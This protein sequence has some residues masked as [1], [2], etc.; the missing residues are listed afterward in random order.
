MFKRILFGIIIAILS[1][2][3][4]SIIAMNQHKEP[5]KPRVASEAEIRKYFR[6]IMPS[7]EQVKNSILGKQG[8]GQL[9]KNKGWKFDVDL[10]W[11]LSDSIRTAGWRTEPQPT[12]FY[13]YEKDGARKC[14]N[15]ADKPCRIH[16]YG[17]SFTHCDQVSNTETWEEYLAGFLH[18]PIRNYGV[19]GYSVYQA[20]LRMLKVEKDHPAEYI[21]LNIWDDDHYRNLAAWHP[22]RYGWQMPDNFTLPHL[23]VD[24]GEK[25]CEQVKNIIQRPEDLYKLC[26]EEF[27]WQTFKDDPSLQIVLACR[28]EAKATAK[29]VNHPAVSFGIPNEIVAD[30]EGTEYIRKRYTEAALFATQNVITW[31]EEFAKK[32][33]KKLMVILSFGHENLT[34]YLKGEPRFDQSLVDWLK[35]KPYP[36]V[37]MCLAFK[38]SMPPNYMQNPDLDIF[39][40]LKRYYI[41]HHNAAGNFFTANAI[42][43]YVVEWLEPKPLPYRTQILKEYQ[44]PISQ[45]KKQ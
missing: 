18:E 17:N 9:S 39:E 15:F 14:I 37:D 13:N 5:V 25:R 31:V 10:G 29:L 4:Y 42:V 2:G 33:D 23:R 24:L 45:T 19:G 20:Y 27:L 12:T 11:V 8:V 43:K 34:K 30:I 21:I 44:W 36:V 41:G 40:Y 6:L 32:N 26:D 22:I 1:T 7:R 35:D 38:E 28:A 16:A 3:G